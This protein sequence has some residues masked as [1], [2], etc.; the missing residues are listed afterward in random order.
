MPENYWQTG[1]IRL[2][3]LEPGDAESFYRWNQDTDTSRLLYQVPLPGSLE[4]VKRW[5]QEQSLRGGENDEY[6]WVIE[7]TV[8]EFAG[9]IGTHHCD[10]RHGN[11]KYGIGIL[12]AHRRKGYAGEAIKLVLRYYFNELRYRKGV[13]EVYGFNEP[14]IRLHENLGFTLEGRLRDM[15][16]SD[17]RFHDLLVFGMLAEEFNTSR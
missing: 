15:I 7:T 3:A 6:N 8:G 16:Y 17:S 10:R 14:S 4:A 11:F 13:A 2:R 12:E 9:S 1:K 5:V